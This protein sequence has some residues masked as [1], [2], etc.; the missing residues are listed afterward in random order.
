[1]QVQQSRVAEAWCLIAN[2]MDDVACLRDLS[3]LS[4]LAEGGPS[5]VLWPAA[6]LQ[7]TTV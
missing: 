7:M 4:E 2:N 6:R 1:M 5:A 3:D